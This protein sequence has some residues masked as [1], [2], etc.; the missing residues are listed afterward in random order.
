MLAVDAGGVVWIFFL[1][2]IM[3]RFFSLSLS[4][5]ETAEY[6]LNYCL[7][8]PFYPN[9]PTKPIQ[10]LLLAMSVGFLSVLILSII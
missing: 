3:S 8:G 10:L 4:L 9:Q 2:P 7:K 6:R 5:W 1:W